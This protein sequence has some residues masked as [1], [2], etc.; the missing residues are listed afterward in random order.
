MQGV[1]MLMGSGKR[2]IWSRPT[3][4]AV[5]CW[6]ASGPSSALYRLALPSMTAPAGPRLSDLGGGGGP[7][8]GSRLSGSAYGQHEKYTPVVMDRSSVARLLTRLDVAG[9]KF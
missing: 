1:H 3:C 6:L 7:R 2:A 8:K 4:A 9:L 5:Y